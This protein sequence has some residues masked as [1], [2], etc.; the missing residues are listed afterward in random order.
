MAKSKSSKRKRS[1]TKSRTGKS[2]RVDRKFQ[3][4][5]TQ[6]LMKKAET[7]YYDIGIENVELYHNCG[8]FITLF[9]GYETSIVDWFNPWGKILKGTGRMNRIGDK[10]TPRGMSIKMF[11]ASKADRPN[12]QYRILICILPK[13]IGGVVTTARFDFRQTPNSG[14][15]ADVNLISRPDTDK[16]I[17]TLYDK[18][19]TL[20]GPYENAGTKEKTKVVNLWIKRK[21][22]RPVVYDTTDTD[23]IN[24]P[25]AIYVIPYEQYSTLETANIA[26]ITG[27]LRMYYKDV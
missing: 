7:K 15:T 16:G 19:V 14:A 24:R 26:S 13:V 9:P 10:I 4:K 1:S 5:V 6:V 18:I 20:P 2:R 21:S 11:L 17:V 8:Q 22:N 12:T 3:A 27:N 25:I 23:I